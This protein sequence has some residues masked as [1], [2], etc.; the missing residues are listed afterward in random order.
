[1]GYGRRFVAA[2]PTTVATVPIGYGDGWRRGLTNDAEVVIRGRRRPLIGTVSMDN[3]TI[4]VGPDTDV[5]RR[6][7]GRR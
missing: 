6:R 7:R 5:A 3:V 2:Q 4:D 1:M